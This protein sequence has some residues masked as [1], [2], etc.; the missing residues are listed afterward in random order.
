MVQFKSDGSIEVDATVDAS[1]YGIRL[2]RL[3]S[4]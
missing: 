2:W 3:R 1:L 4:R